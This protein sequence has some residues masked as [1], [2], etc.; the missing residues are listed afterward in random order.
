MITNYETKEVHI[1]T[2][3]P[4]DT[5]LHRDYLAAKEV[6]CTVCKSN[7][8][9]DDGFMGMSIFGDSYHSGHKKVKLVTFITK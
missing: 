2:I 5:I 6:L 1:S 7:I 3:R 4:G 9:K 8:K